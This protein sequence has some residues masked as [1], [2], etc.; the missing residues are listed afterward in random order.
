MLLV[1]VSG[2]NTAMA[3]TS[4]PAGL[5][6]SAIWAVAGAA[7]IAGAVLARRRKRRSQQAARPM[8]RRSPT[9]SSAPAPVDAVATPHR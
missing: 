8:A 9:T 6:Q 2:F 4:T 1:G 5:Y 3:T 7:V